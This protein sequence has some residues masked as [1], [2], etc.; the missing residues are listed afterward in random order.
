MFKNTRHFYDRLNGN[1]LQIFHQMI[2]QQQ[3]ETNSILLSFSEH[4]LSLEV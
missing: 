2:D 3:G 1:T 4:N